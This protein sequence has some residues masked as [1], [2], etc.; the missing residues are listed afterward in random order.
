MRCWLQR[1]QRPPLRPAIRKVHD[2]D[3]KVM[4]FMSNV[5]ISVGSVM[6]PAGAANG[7]GIISTR[8]FKD[9][10][11]PTWDNDPAMRAFKRFMAKYVPG[12]DITDSSYVQ[13]YDASYTM[14]KVLEACGGDYARS[15]VLKQTLSL[16][17]L[18]VPL[19]LPGIKLN[20]SATN[21]HPIRA[22][23][24]VRWD[25]ETWVRFG[26]VIEGGAT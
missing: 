3:W 9:A 26:D 14:L 19:L 2:L 11:D 4:F 13:G 22:M 12:G 18:E 1:R 16:R 17:E 15:N 10:T 20:T 8:Y 23:Q 6:R 5:A 7:I 25:G 24:L 21:D